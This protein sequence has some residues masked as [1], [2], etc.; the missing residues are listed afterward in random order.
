MIAVNHHSDA[1]PIYC[2]VPIEFIQPWDQNEAI[3]QVKQLGLGNMIILSGTFHVGGDEDRAKWKT[4]YP[5]LATIVDET[6][7]FPERPEYG[8]ARLIAMPLEFRLE[9]LRLCRELGLKLLCW[10]LA[11]LGLRAEDVEPLNAAAKEIVLTE[12]TLCENTS[13]LGSTIPLEKL[14]KLDA[15]PITDHSQ[16]DTVTAR[17]DAPPSVFDDP[18]SLDFRVVH[19]WFVKRFKDHSAKMRAQ[20]GYPISAVEAT[21]QMRLAMECGVDMPL[22]ELVPGEP[23]RGLATTRGAV[24]AYGKSEWGVHTAMGYYRAPTDAWTPERLRIAYDLFF[25]GGA[26]IFSEPNIAIRNWGSCSAFFSVRASPPIRQGELE[27]REFDD[28]ICVRGREVLADHYRFTQFHRR[29]TAS[30]RVRLGFL[31]GY[32]D[33][34]VGGAASADRMWMVDDPGFLAPDAL[35]M[36]RHFDRVFDSE[37]WYIVPRKYYWQADPAKPL[38]HGTPPCG[39]V[40][41][42]PIEAPVDVLQSYRTLALL[43][44]NTMTRENYAKLRGFVGNGG[45]LFL[46]VPHLSTRTRT[47]R[48]QNFINDGDVRDLCGVKIRAAGETVDEFYFANQTSSDRYVFPQGA[49]YL[50]DAPLASL[51][52]HGARVL[53]HARENPNLPLLLEHRV[54]KGVVYLLATSEYPG[55]RLD[56]LITDI[57]RTLA[58][59]EQSNIAVESRD[60][61]YAIYDGEM[62]S[63]TPFSSIY[64]VNHDIYG[65]PASATMTWNKHRTSL[66]V[67]GREMRIAWMF[68]DLLVSPMSRFVKITDARRDGNAWTIEIET[69]TPGRQLIQIESTKKGVAKLNGKPP[70]IRSDLDGATYVEAELSNRHTLTYACT[71]P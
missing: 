49:L 29:P 41:I 34:W 35:K 33:G 46:S 48:P 57:L 14:R 7:R 16:R 66:R 1:R 9:Q 13:I 50:E 42:V 64:L 5:S 2:C 59:G 52:L 71:S 68:D 62:P 8:M 31:L 17:A 37:P 19:D 54:G 44:W 51:E 3:R 18:A 21:T 63:R 15:T 43:G 56:A 26:S 30:P 27:C 45:T 24:K 61:F 55:A 53:A 36:W 28:P 12:M 70:S 11:G 4:L 23:Q 60:V 40:D 39:Q 22:Y 47:D 32:L 69:A 25:A 10:M 67:S 20:T 38:R 58:E 6:P 65:Q